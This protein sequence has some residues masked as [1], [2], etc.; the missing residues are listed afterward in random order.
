M[1]EEA[2]TVTARAPGPVS[3]WLSQ[4]GFKHA[5]LPVDHL[6]VELLG[7]EPPLLPFV[8]T[9]LEASGFDHLQCP[10]GYDE[11]TAV[12]LVSFYNLTKLERLADHIAPVIAPAG[13]TQAILAVLRSEGGAPA[14][15]CAGMAPSP[16]PASMACSAASIGR[17]VKPASCSASTTK[18]SLTPSDC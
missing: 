15:V 5:V 7:I 17:R 11:A 13:T 8:V 6:E 3:T 18:A 2:V 14:G 4:Q 9:A 1:P 12:R 10:G 16:Y